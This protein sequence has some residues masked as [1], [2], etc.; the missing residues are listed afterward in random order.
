MA[1]ATGKAPAA[2]VALN[3]LLAKAH[4]VAIPKAPTVEHVIED[5]SASGRRLSPSAL[6][7]QDQ[8]SAALPRG[9]C[10][11]AMRHTRIPDFLEATCEG[12]VEPASRHE[13][14]FHR[15]KTGGATRD[16]CGRLACRSRNSSAHCSRSR[17]MGA[18]CPKTSHHQP[19]ARET[20]STDR[21]PQ[22]WTGT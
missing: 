14:G 12:K 16:K 20:G 9:V 2:Q 3:W 8:I 4:V 5:C 18:G 21:V 22:R 13:T 17:V 7:Q 11:K 15:C 19:N 1:E 10:G 6:G